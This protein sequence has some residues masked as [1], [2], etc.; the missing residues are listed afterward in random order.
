[1]E[2][3]ESQN[4]LPGKSEEPID[5]FYWYMRNSTTR[6]L[7]RMLEIWDNEERVSW[8]WWIEAALRIVL[9]TSKENK[10]KISEKTQLLLLKYIKSELRIE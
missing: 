3:C 2:Q 6:S 7:S 1:M 4:D 8:R 5:Q 9:C 10:E